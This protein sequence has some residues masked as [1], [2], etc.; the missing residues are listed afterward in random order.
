MDSSLSGSS[1][2]GISQAKILEWVV[3]SSS[4]GSSQPRDRTPISCVYCID[5][6]SLTTVPLGKPT[7]RSSY[8]YRS[9]WLLCSQLST[10][11]MS[12]YRTIPPNSPHFPFFPSRLFC[13]PVT[14]DTLCLFTGAHHIL[15]VFYHFCFIALLRL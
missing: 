4:R 10:F 9:C 11:P 3:I 13:F 14:T 7:F 12:F 6:G 5:K 2:Q 1:V 8:I 15:P